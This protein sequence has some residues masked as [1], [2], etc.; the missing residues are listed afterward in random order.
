MNRNTEARAQRR[1]GERQQREIKMERRTKEKGSGK[2]LKKEKCGEG[3][4]EN[5]QD[6]IIKDKEETC[7]KFGFFLSSVPP[8]LSLLEAVACM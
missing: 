5:H 3:G 1:E 6:K 7:R 8:C 4:Y 2:K